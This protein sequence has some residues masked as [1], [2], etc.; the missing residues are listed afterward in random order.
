MP[1]AEAADAVTRPSDVIAQVGAATRELCDAL[2][3][4]IDLR[5]P[6]DLPG[7]TRLTIACHLRYGAEA[8]RR[9]VGDAVAGRPTSYYPEG[10]AAQRPATLLPRDGEAPGDVLRS[11]Q[12]TSAALQSAW[13]AVRDWSI[14]VT[15]PRDN[16]DLGPF[17]LANQPILRLT[18]VEVHGTDLS[19]GLGPWSDVLVHHALPM[20]LAWLNTRRSNHRAVDPSVQGELLLQATDGP[21][22]Q[23]MRISGDQVTSEP[24][25]DPTRSPSRSARVIRASSRDLLALLLG[26]WTDGS[27][28]AEAFRRAFPGP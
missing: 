25:A 18:E 3:S 1:A 26:R 9:M 14:M 27:H 17:P 28:A 4:G 19:I 24:A 10:R 8:M 6:S 12:D 15:E 13:E 5:A 22:A 7:W 11:L 21:I 16:A 23:R 20:R 2:G